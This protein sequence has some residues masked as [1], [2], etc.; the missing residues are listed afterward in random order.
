MCFNIFYCL[1]F[2][3]YHSKPSSQTCNNTWLILFSLFPL[4]VGL[5]L[6]FALILHLFTLFLGLPFSLYLTV[7]FFFFSLHDNFANSSFTIISIYHTYLRIK[8]VIF[9]IFIFY[10]EYCVRN[11]S[12]FSPLLA[13]HYGH[14]LGDMCL[15][16]Y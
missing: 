5:M 1:T 15:Q 9:Y 8:L 12:F 3:L 7:S 11:Q 2:I 16:Y 13:K 10:R 6:H 14:V 4:P